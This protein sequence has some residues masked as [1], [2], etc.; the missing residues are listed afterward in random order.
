MISAFDRV[1]H[2]DR[3]SDVSRLASQKHIAGAGSGTA[4]GAERSAD[5]RTHGT[6]AGGP[7]LAPGL[8]P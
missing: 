6:G 5:D 8:H 7:S 2:P 3:P 4:G 1:I